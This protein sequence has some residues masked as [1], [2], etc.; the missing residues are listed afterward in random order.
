MVAAPDGS[1]NSS[2]D[3]QADACLHDVR[4]GDADHASDGGC[5]SSSELV[6]LEPVEPWLGPCE[7][8]AE[9]ARCTLLSESLEDSA[10]KPESNAQEDGATKSDSHA[11][12]DSAAKTE[13]S[14]QEDGAVKSDSN[15]QESTAS[16]NRCTQQASPPHGTP[17]PVRPRRSPNRS[18]DARKPTSRGILL[19]EACPAHLAL[20][21]QHGRR[22]RWAGLGLLD[23]ELPSTTAL[24]ALGVKLEVV[25]DL[26][27]SNNKLMGVFMPRMLSPCR[28]LVALRAMRLFN[29]A[30]GDSSAAFLAQMCVHCPVLIE[31]HLSHNLLT[32]WGVSEIVPAA[33]RGSA[34]RRKLL[35]ARKEGES[36][37]PSPPFWL[38]LEHN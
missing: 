23:E 37:Q 2:P 34:Q 32:A 9:T 13:S 14:A 29:N 20:P 25:R 11:Q 1:R 10:A 8:S 28:R 36:L 18:S 33:C 3:N 38:R 30:L 35:A 15:A 26:D 27:L 22:L 21:T 4:G 19:A 6:Q 5:S 16:L 12:E 17:R 31:L 7:D 24:P